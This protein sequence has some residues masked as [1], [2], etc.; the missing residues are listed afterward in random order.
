MPIPNENALKTKLLLLF[1][2][3]AL[4]TVKELHATLF[5]KGTN[6]TIQGI[7]R[8]LRALIAE[9]IIHKVG[10]SYILNSHWVLRLQAFANLA[11][12]NV[13]SESGGLFLLPQQKKQTWKFESLLDMDILWGHIVLYYL[14]NSDDKIKLGWHPYSWFYLIHSENERLFQQSLRFMGGRF[15]LIVG[16]SC[17][18]NRWASQFMARDKIIYSMSPGPFKN[19]MDTYITV[20]GDHIVTVKM[21]PETYKRISDLFENTR[22]IESLPIGDLTDLFTKHGH[23]T[24]TL[25][26]NPQKAKSLRAKFSEYFG[27]EL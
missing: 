26:H 17:F 4:W 16:N 24:L 9:N 19:K 10:D 22:N 13:F 7:Y 12:R 15:Y 11:S 21:K 27:E 5:E 20:T 2:G 3:K 8:E 6:C 18:V 14:R 25:E 1:G 23:C